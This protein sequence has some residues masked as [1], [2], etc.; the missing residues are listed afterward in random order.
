MRIVDSAAKM[1]RLIEDILRFSRLSRAG[2]NSGSVDL[3][4]LAHASLRELGTS[5]AIS[6][7]S[8]D[9][10]PPAV[11]DEALLKQ[12]LVNLLDNALKYSARQEQPE[13]RVGAIR[14]AGETVY[15]VEDNGVGFAMDAAERLFSVFHRLHSDAEFPGTGVGLAIVKQIVER[16]GGRVWAEA[17]PG[18]GAKFYFTLGSN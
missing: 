4:L 7:V 15:F 5:H 14:Q 1:G 8:I 10:L 13:V 2:L 16:H 6:N 12:V 11:G 18:R 3:E 9:T 17:A